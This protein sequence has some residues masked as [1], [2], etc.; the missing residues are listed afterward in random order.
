MSLKNL[1]KIA[2]SKS[3]ELALPSW[4]SEKNITFAAYNYIEQLK[5]MK[6]DFIAKHNRVNDYKVK[7]NYQI[8]ASEVARNIKVATTTL[9]ST[10]AYSKDL[11]NYLDSINMKLEEEKS[12]RLSKHRKTLSS[13]LRQH[14]KDEI[15]IELQNT[16]K[17]LEELKNKNAIEQATLILKSLALPIK[18]KLGINI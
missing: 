12:L 9:I 2:H 16:R 8:T 6:L 7:G 1:S 11:K 3:T 17:E 13:G 18:Q 5:T 10:S 15:R 14:K 4:V